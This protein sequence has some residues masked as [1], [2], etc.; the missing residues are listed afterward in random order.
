[1]FPLLISRGIH[2]S[3]GKRFWGC[4]AVCRLSSNVS[5]AQI[6]KK[7]L[8]N[9]SNVNVVKNVATK[10]VDPVIQ[11]PGTKKIRKTSTGGTNVEFFIILLVVLVLSFS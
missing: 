3:S 5:Y 1:M 8:Q 2:E 4:S 7:G 10:Y 11:V 6:A 9:N